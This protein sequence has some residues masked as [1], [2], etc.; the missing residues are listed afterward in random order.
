MNITKSSRKDDI[1]AAYEALQARPTT[2]ADTWTLT[3]STARTVVREARLLAIDIYKGGCL[4]RQW[5]RV[6]I[7]TYRQPV[8]RSKA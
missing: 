1:W 5:V 8:L 7:D 4:A 6:V 2:W 3:A